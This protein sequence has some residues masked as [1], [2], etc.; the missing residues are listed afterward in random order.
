MTG[1]L[2]YEKLFYDATQKF[3]SNSDDTYTK[4]MKKEQTVLD[5][6]N[7]VV[8]QKE[9]AKTSGSLLDKPLRHI[10]YKTYTELINIVNDIQEQKHIAKIL[11]TDRY[12]PI[13]LF[14]VTV[15]T[16][17]VILYYFD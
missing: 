3:I 14:L 12:I 1:N 7:K 13:G 10:V 8:N 6:V 16:I 4:L 5:V 15:S 9:E 11:S 17:F 2:E